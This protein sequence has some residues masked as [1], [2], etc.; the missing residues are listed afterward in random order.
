MPIP[1]D[2]LDWSRY[3][4]HHAVF[5]PA[6]MT[7]SELQRET[8]KAMARFYSWRTIIKRMARL[9]FYYGMIGIYAK[10]SVR[11][12]SLEGE[13]YLRELDKGLKSWVPS[14]DCAPRT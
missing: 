7:P 2:A 13:R 10:R 9:D 3:D 1:P 5:R 4:A 6:R 14:I 12:A 11:K 8:F